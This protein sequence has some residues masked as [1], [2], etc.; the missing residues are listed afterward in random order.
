MPS[1]A[2]DELVIDSVKCGEQAEG[3]G[4][5]RASTEAIERRVLRPPETVHTLRCL[6]QGQE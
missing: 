2:F 4:M 1:T 3:G 5:K 6:R